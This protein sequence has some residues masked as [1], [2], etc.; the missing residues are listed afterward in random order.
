MRRCARP[1]ARVRPRRG[2]SFST[3]PEDPATP[4]RVN[5]PASLSSALWRPT[6]SRTISVPVAG[7]QKAAACTARVSWLSFCAAGRRSMASIRA[8]AGTLQ[9]AFQHP[10]DRAWLV[11]GSLCRTIHSQSGRPL[12]AAARH[13][14]SAARP[15]ASYAIRS[16]AGGDD[17]DIEGP[18]I[19]VDQPFGQREADAKSSRSAA[20][21]S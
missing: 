20:S 9:G 5:A 12:S 11:R 21:P 2:W 16:R 1:F 4:W 19:G 15:E 8:E 14:A 18:H 7:F 3:T 13:I 17:F 10:A 6:S